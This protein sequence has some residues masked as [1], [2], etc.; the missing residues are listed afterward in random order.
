MLSNTCILKSKFSIIFSI[1]HRDIKLDNILLDYR[2]NVKLIDFGFSINWKPTNKLKV[3][4]GTPCY[5]A[6]EIIS[7]KPYY[8]ST[9]DIWAWGIILY[10]L[11]VGKF[12]FQGTSESELYSRIK[13]GIFKLPDT[14][15]FNV[16]KLIGKML[17]LDP[18]KRPTANELY[19]DEWIR[20]DAKCFRKMTLKMINDQYANNPLAKLVQGDKPNAKSLLS[21][22]KDW[23]PSTRSSLA[24][25]R[26][27]PEVHLKAV[28]KIR[29]MGYNYKQISEKLGDWTSD[30]NRMYMN[31][32]K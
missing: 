32:I 19:Y 9:V 6:P 11:L 24:H 16:R 27:D 4:W 7:K 1:Y 14:I 3:F 28:D 31:L 10:I 30:V 13:Q 17:S 22:K 23:R 15:S 18:V 21:N 25:K 5:M 12:P 29:H 2:R 26:I 8:G 20:G